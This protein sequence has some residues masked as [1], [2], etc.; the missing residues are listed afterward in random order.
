MKSSWL[1]ASFGSLGDQLLNPKGLPS[2]HRNCPSVIVSFPPS[3]ILVSVPN[4]SL[5]TVLTTACSAADLMDTMAWLLDAQC[6][7]HSSRVLEPSTY[8]FSAPNLAGFSA[9]ADTQHT[10]GCVLPVWSS[11]AVPS[12]Q[13]MSA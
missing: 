10:D 9:D 4:I 8:K 5:R 7:L 2:S 3:Q 11:Q 1:A 12:S 6:D 13:L